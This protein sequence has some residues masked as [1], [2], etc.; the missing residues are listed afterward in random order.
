MQIE[1]YLQN[2]INL[3]SRQQGPDGWAIASLII[4]I[5]DL[6]ATIIGLGF[7]WSEIYKS[8]KA[9]E[10]S[11][12]Q[13]LF[14]R[15]LRC[16]F[17]HKTIFNEINRNMNDLQYILDA[18]LKERNMYINLAFQALFDASEIHGESLSNDQI[19]R[20]MNYYNRK[21]DAI[22][23]LPEETEILFK[24]SNVNPRLFVDDYM[25]MLYAL[26]WARQIC[27]NA[28]DKNA[29][30]DAYIKLCDAIKSLKT[31]MNNEPKILNLMKKEIDLYGEDKK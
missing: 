6:I 3:L 7:A 14:D 30:N 27:G 16:Y 17:M 25:K 5:V 21:I 31:S 11:N 8:R 2:I 4:S 18:S 22:Q 15:R 26:H 28:H 13:C 1:E 10:L 12:K 23:I 24:F 20:A 19:F 9:T 29:K